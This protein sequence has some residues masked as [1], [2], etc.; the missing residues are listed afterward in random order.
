MEWFYNEE[1]FTSSKI[2]VE[3]QK[4][5]E[6]LLNLEEPWSFMIDVA[7]SLYTGL[8]LLTGP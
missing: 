7:K 5:D 3:Y 2:N 1:N 8:F 6:V 4:A